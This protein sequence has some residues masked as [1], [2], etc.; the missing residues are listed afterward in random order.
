MGTESQD[1]P[2]FIWK[3]EPLR[4][5]RELLDAMFA[6]DHAEEAAF[7]MAE[8]RKANEHADQNAGYILGYVEPPERRR[9]M[10]ELFMV[11]HPVFGGAP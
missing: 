11:S 10:Y 1:A 4:S 7:F 3:G 2:D 6:I 8:Y 9:A 5:I